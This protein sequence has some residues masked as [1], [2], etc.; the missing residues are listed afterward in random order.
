[1]KIVVDSNIV[2]SA[3]LNTKSNI[4]HLLIEGESKFNFY[5]IYQLI[6]EINTYKY[7]ILTA[8]KYSDETLNSIF[9]LLKNQICF[10]D[11]NDISEY[12]KRKAIETTRDIDSNDSFFIAL[13][14][15]MNA[16]LWTGDKKLI[17]GLHA[18]GLDLTITTAELL[19]ISE[20]L[21]NYNF[22]TN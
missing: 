22:I 7:K 5:S 15:E 8:T 12:N 11:L 2:F 6:D 16:K 17:N 4:G 21:D 1:L 14:L 3:I 13:A 20:D 10:V 9:E 18:K 19:Q